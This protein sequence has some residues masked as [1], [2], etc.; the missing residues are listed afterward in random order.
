MVTRPST[1][2]WSWLLSPS[3]AVVPPISTV[4]VESSANAKSP[5]TVRKP[6]DWPGET[7]PSSVTDGAVMSVP[8]WSWIVPPAMVTGSVKVAVSI[9]TVPEP[10][11][12]S[13]IVM[14][15][16]PSARMPISVSSMSRVPDPPP[17][18]MLSVGVFGLMVSTPWPETVPELSLRLS[19]IRERSP[20]IKACPMAAL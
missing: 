3:P 12:V 6:G 9:S 20:V 18:P 10:L 15:V 4:N 14:D 19:V 13:P 16:N 8:A 5:S 7:L 11:V 2:S 1:Q 17:M